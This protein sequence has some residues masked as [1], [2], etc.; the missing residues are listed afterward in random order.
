MLYNVENLVHTAASNQVELPNKCWV[1]ARPI[2]YKCD[3]V[4][5]RIK[6]AWLVLLGKADAI[7]WEGQ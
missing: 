1:Y 5:D 7:V 2:N 6:H 3:S 4:L